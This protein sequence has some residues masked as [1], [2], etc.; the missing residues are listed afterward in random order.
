M[1]A[2]ICTHKRPVQY[3][4]RAHMHTAYS[5]AISPQ[6]PGVFSS[7]RS[8]ERVYATRRLFQQ[9]DSPAL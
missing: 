5:S 8:K 9:T 1:R 4:D 3:V 6:R 7:D 2:L